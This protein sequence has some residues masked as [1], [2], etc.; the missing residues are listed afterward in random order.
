MLQT[1]TFVPLS[2]FERQLFTQLVPEDDFLLLLRRSVDFERFRASLAVHYCPDNGRPS[3]DPVM[4]LKLDLLS[5]H[6]RWSDRELLRHARV[7]MAVRLFLNIGCQTKLPHHTSMTY[8]RQRV[9]ADAIQEIFHGVLAQAREL[10]LVSDRLR[11]KDATHVIANIAVPSTIRL[12]AETR[13][14]VLDAAEPFDPAQVAYEWQRADGISAVADED[15]PDSERLIRRVEHLRRLL[16]WADDV[17]ATQAFRT[18]P[19]TQRAKLLAALKLA[20]KVLNDRDEPQA[21]DKVISVQDPDARC[22]KHGEFF[23]GYL[24]D[25]T[26]DADSELLT[27]V[28]VLPA[29]GDE[30]G[31]AAYLIEQEETAHG[32]D[33]AGISMDGAGFRGTVL[34]DLTDPA[35][36]NL[37][38]FTPP[39]EPTPLPGFGPEQ[40]T[41]SDDGTTLT[42]PAGQTT[43]HYERS[44][45][46]TG[47]K[48]RFSKKQ[49]GSCPLREQCLANA[50]TKSRTVIKN[51]YETEYRAARE[52]SQTPQYAKVR[53]EHPAIERKLA[54]MARRHDLRHARYRGLQKVRRQALLTG[55]TI[56]LKRIVKLRTKVLDSAATGTVRAELV[57]QE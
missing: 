40:F 36:L 50:A 17:P 52:K 38:V 32:N 3:L 19:A 33:V 29:N 8:F 35:G 56:N 45:S 31:D 18:A 10:G 48:F 11:L 1:E 53:K 16:L 14:E 12:V 41:R 7:N 43:T 28:N 20:H 46:G 22:G 25:V 54:E 24:V 49:C 15:M 23:D 55:L 2:E 26:M 5:I 47:V 51:D 21:G 42:C 39:T 34:R 9:G 13:D 4:M 30:G 37:E 57:T 44:S 6:Y 27:G